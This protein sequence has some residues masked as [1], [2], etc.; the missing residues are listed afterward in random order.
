M[1][2]LQKLPKQKKKLEKAEPSRTNTCREVRR[3]KVRITKAG[4]EMQIPKLNQNF[5]FFLTLSGAKD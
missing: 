1:K 4:N 5:F 2:E 3:S